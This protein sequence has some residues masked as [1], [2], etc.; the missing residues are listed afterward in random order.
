MI[1]YFCPKCKKRYLVPIS[2]QGQAQEC[3]CGNINIVPKVEV[4][5][6]KCSRC[7]STQIGAGTKGFSLG[8]AA[9]GG[10]LLGPVG[11]LGGLLGSKETMVT[12]LKCG[13]RWNPNVITPLPPESKETPPSIS[14]NKTNQPLAKPLYTNDFPDY[15]NLRSEVIK[16]L[17]ENKQNQ[18]LKQQ[19]N[20]I[21]S[22]NS[23]PGDQFNKPMDESSSRETKQYVIIRCPL[24]QRRYSIKS[25]MQREIE[26]VK[27]KEVRCKECKKV[28]NVE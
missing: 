1:E 4:S 16:E 11:L 27:I 22:N 14:E 17:K 25:K 15:T 10:V 19:T 26:K 20:K 21:S 28:F 23:P 5:S 18:F 8:K 7:G 2:A 6:I 12:C 13:H 24:C 9:V 3:D